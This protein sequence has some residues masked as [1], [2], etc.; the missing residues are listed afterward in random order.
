MRPM[1]TLLLVLGEAA[2]KT[3]N[4]I[5]VAG[6]GKCGTNALA[7]HVSALVGFRPSRRDKQAQV[8]LNG[9]AGEVNYP[10]CSF[11]GGVRPAYEQLLQRSKSRP[12]AGRISRLPVESES[13]S[14]VAARAGGPVS[15]SGYSV[16]TWPPPLWPTGISS[17]SRCETTGRLC[18]TRLR[19]SF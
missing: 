15:P 2:A 16:Q 4:L 12:G 14:G 7:Y 11:A 9:F 1:L 17:H 18:G 3:R 19:S 13:E 8:K 5:V 10:N 6:A